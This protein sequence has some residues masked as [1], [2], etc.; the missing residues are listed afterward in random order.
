MRM[1]ERKGLGKGKGKG[2]SNIAPTDPKIH[3]DSA[4]GIKQPQK[5]SIFTKIGHQAKKTKERVDTL[6]AQ[7]KAESLEKEKQ[8][9]I[10]EQ[11][12]LETP[13]YKKMKSQERRVS[14]LRYQIEKTN[15]EDKKGEL[16]EELVAEE[17]ELNQKI[18]DIADVK[19]EDYTDRELKD[20]AVRNKGNDGFFADLFGEGENIYEKELIRRTRARKKINAK[21]KEAERRPLEKEEGLFEDLF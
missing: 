21:V 14:E 17:Y 7:K 2:Y 13:E 3:S 11:R 9:R 12:E 20:L 18:E 6:V 8:K 1:V 15:D 16:Q 19:L 10:F 5:V 4:N